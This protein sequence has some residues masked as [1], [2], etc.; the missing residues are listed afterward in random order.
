MPRS[1]VFASIAAIAAAA[2]PLATAAP[3]HAQTLRIAMTATDIPTTTGMPNN[4]FEGMR[5]LGYPIFE[6]LILWDLTKTDALAGLK[7]GLAESWTQ[8]PDDKKTWIFK[9]RPNV[10]FHDGTP[11]NADAVIWNLDRYF[12]TDSPQFEA[13]GSG[14]TRARVPIMAGYKKIDDM[15]VSMTT[16]VPASYFPYMVVYVLFTSPA[17]FEKAGNDWGKVATLPAAGTGPFKITKVT[18]REVVELARNDAYWDA[19]RKPKVAGVRLLPIPDANSRIAA[20]RSGQVDW[21]E[22]PPPDGIPSLKSAGFT[23]T[24]GSYPHVWPWIYN[25]GATNSPL[26]DVKVRQALNYCVDRAGLVEMLN[27]VAEP[28]VGWLKAS[29]PHFG[30]PKNRYTF[31]PAKGKALLA[32]AGYTAAK[33]LSFKVMVSTSGSGQMLPLPMNEFVQS[34]LKEAC[35][36]NVEVNAVEWQVLLTAA[37]ATPD[38]PTL[39]GASALNVSSPSSDIGVMAR[40]FAKSSFSPNGFNF[41]QWADDQFEASLK[42]LA[43]ATDPKEITAATKAVHERLVDNPPWLYIVHDLNP[44]AMSGKVK[45]FVS[46][47]SWFVDLT[48]VSLQ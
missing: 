13:P 20:L 26:K 41:P 22:V 9:L 18:P 21:I 17:S 14:I 16:T 29:D 28:S 1:F 2:V 43:E 6:G 8:S 35:G 40:Y 34:N 11:F 12:K 19:S 39:A 24:T 33:P 4:G 3:A 25:I 5:F 7:A 47:Q 48:T 42:T 45:G 27:G 36:V 23:I 10:A 30:A 44:R 15:T 46:P 38:A 32:E 31:D 37:R